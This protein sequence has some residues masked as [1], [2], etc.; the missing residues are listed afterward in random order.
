VDI[1]IPPY[2]RPPLHRYGAVNA[3]NHLERERIGEQRRSVFAFFRG[4]TSYRPGL[5]VLASARGF[6]VNAGH[7]AP[8]TYEAEL[9]ISTFCLC[10]PG[11]VSWTS[12]LFQVMQY[13]VSFLS[14]FALN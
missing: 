2:V 9:Y 1:V 13:V 6:R 3:T 12:R 5:K 11:W 10:P 8:S 4:E 7:V 14:L